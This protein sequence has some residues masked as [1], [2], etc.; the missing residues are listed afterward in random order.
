MFKSLIKI[1]DLK[2][3]GIL[4]LLATPLINLVAPV[5]H[6]FLPLIWLVVIDILSGIYKNRI[7]K[8][9]PIT[10]KKFFERKSKV[11]LV[12]S[13]GLVTMLL[14]DTFLKEIGIDGHWGAKVY[15]VWYALYEVISILENIGDSGLP[16]AK[17]ILKLLRGKL[18]ANIDKSLEKEESNNEI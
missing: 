14:A 1:D 10:S 6:L 5:Q 4:S 13:A 8:K 9:E 17:S 16:G 3:S 11:V 18:P 15:C 7:Y 12:W 2:L